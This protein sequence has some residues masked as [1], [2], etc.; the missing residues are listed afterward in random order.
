MTS[1]AGSLCLR[2][3]HILLQHDLGNDRVTGDGVLAL[4]IEKLYGNVEWLLWPVQY[5]CKWGFASLNLHDRTVV[6]TLA[7]A[8]SHDT[9]SLGSSLFTLSIWKSSMSPCAINLSLASSLECTRFF[10]F[11]LSIEGSRHDKIVHPGQTSQ[12]LLHSFI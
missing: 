9:Q 6:T 12:Y 11:N 1:G 5:F 2:L 8:R 4:I 7:K 10:V 3:I